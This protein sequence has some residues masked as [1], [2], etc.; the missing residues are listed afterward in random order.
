MLHLRKCW[1]PLQEVQ[2]QENPWQ[3]DII[4]DDLSGTGGTEM[5]QRFLDRPVSALFASWSLLMRDL[6]FF[7]FNSNL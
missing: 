3:I 5:D 4:L 1:V 2:L 7:S 6:R